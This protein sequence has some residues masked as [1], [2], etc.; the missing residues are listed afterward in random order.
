MKGATIG[1][2][3]LTDKLGEGGMGSVYLAEHT[4]IRRKAAIKLLN[5]DLCNN[6]EM[7]NRFFNEAKAASSINHPGIVEI[8]DYG[9]HTDN[10]AFIVMQHLQGET[11]KERIKRMGR[12]P[13]PMAVTFTR[14]IAG[15]LGAAHDAGIVHRDLK[16]DNI[17]LVRDPEVAG[18]ER[19]RIL[20]FGIAKLTGA[21]DS[22][23][24]TG[25]VMGTPSYMSPEQCMGAGNVDSRTDI[26]A[27]GCILFHMLC[28]QP[29]FAGDGWSLIGAH[30]YQPP[31]APSSVLPTIPPA[32]EQMILRMLAKEPDN[33]FANAERLIAT[34]DSLSL[35]MQ[36][37]KVHVPGASSAMAAVSASSAMAAV[38]AP[39]AMAAV[40]APP[41]VA[42][43]PL[44]TPVPMVPPAL[45]GPQA[46]SMP[47][48]AL[49]A[50]MP[51]GYAAVP[52]AA[53]YPVS[54]AGNTTLSS[55]AGIGVPA[56]PRKKPYLPIAIGLVV[57]GA[58]IGG[59]MMVMQNKET[60]Q[61]A[62]PVAA[63]PAPVQ[64]AAA[65]VVSPQTPVQPGSGQVAPDVAPPQTNSVSIE[66][67][68]SGAEIFRKLDGV[69]L[70][71]T[72]QK[73]PAPRDGDLVFVLKL[74]GYE[75][76][77]L[78]IRAGQRQEYKE[79]LVRVPS[80]SS[81]SQTVRSGRDE[82]EESQQTSKS[83]TPEEPL[84]P[85]EKDNEQ[86]NPFEK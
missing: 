57:A 43:R 69:R 85:F 23:T 20:D 79:T 62:A 13:V 63:L 16:P 46:G 35:D 74:D 21:G 68:P 15:A 51:A 58:A 2:Y 52:A 39:S 77:E 49:A 59:G 44:G 71:S 61:A 29:P 8:Y 55:A 19:I 10:G 67:E 18:G 38:S 30:I 1:S 11:L 24:R 76:K 60:S 28:G 14:Q 12:L 83:S 42:T 84:N 33:R 34:I 65:P 82:R 47:F 56:Q 80:R 72:P 70:G 64:P 53:A 50:A 9:Y 41:D 73:L 48:A 26:Y 66:S 6:P 27:L 3:T 75:D 32:L 25:T 78:V 86:L 54:A 22:Q 36:T 45:T 31:P 5:S 17:F 37:I 4:L 7:I 81:K 40:S